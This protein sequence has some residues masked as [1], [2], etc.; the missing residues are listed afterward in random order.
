LQALGRHNY[1]D[2]QYDLFDYGCGKGSDIQILQ[3]NEITA[4]GWGPHFAPDA[5]VKSSDIV[6]L[7]FVLNV[8]EDSDERMEALL[9]VYSL[10]QKLL[11]DTF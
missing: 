1:L 6:N 8:I 3:Q 11:L 5:P 2:G 10:R 9:N 7:G 4:S